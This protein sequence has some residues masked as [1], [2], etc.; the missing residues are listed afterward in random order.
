VHH[1]SD[2][3]AGGVMLGTNLAIGQWFGRPFAKDY[4]GAIVSYGQGDERYFDTGAVT[5]GLDAAA[6]ATAGPG[7]T[8]SISMKTIEHFTGQAWYQHWWTDNVRTSLVYG[9][10]LWGYGGIPHAVD[11]GA[12]GT[13]QLSQVQTGYINLIWSPVKS[14]NI[15]L[16]FMF[17]D[18]TKRGLGGAVGPCGTSQCGGNNGDAKRLMASLQYVF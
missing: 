10:G 1:S 2:S 16:E 17:G 7:G 6:V 13:S 12:V 5:P 4:I 15:G 14:V 9:I 18:L 3:I 8:F 11:T